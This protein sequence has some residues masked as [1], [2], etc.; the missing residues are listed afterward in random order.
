MS[1]ATEYLLTNE[2]KDIT[3]RRRNIIMAL[4][5]GIYKGKNFNIDAIINGTMQSAIKVV[6]D[7]DELVRRS[8]RLK[9]ETPEN[10]GLEFKKHGTEYSEFL[11]SYTPSL[12]IVSVDIIRNFNL[13]LGLNLE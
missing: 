3:T 11:Q 1:I 10:E 2:D 13:G 4:N 9:G 8:K 5:D 6:D 12:N 7:G